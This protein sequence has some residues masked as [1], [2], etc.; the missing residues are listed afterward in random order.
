MAAV[1][2]CKN[3]LLVGLKTAVKS[4]VTACIFSIFFSDFQPFDLDSFLESLHQRQ[5]QEQQD[6]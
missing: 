3:T 2:S 1:A 5:Q 6:Q 4:N